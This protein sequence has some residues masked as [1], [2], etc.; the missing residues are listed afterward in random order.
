MASYIA[1]ELYP[2]K[3]QLL[4]TR[5]IGIL[6]CTVDDYIICKVY[7]LYSILYNYAALDTINMLTLH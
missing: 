3:V 7:M 4:H 1:S 2:L 6:I 5:Y